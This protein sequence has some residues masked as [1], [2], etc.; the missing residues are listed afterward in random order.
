MGMFERR[1]VR[2]ASMAAQ[3]SWAVSEQWREADSES[4][5]PIYGEPPAAGVRREAR[6]WWLGAERSAAAG[7]ST[8]RSWRTRSSRRSIRPCDAEAR[9]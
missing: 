8:R 7:E 4:A 5:R 2:R 1:Y 9:E 3:R 6:E